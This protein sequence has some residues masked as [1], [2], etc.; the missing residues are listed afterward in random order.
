MNPV[1]ADCDKAQGTLVPATGPLPL[2]SELME[3][4]PPKATTMEQQMFS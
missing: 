1:P 3:A 4:V 2:Y